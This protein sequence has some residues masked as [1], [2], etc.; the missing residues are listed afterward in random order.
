MNL[1]VL[2]SLLPVALLVVALLVPAAPGMTV[3]KQEAQS[4]Y[5]AD[6]CWIS[7]STTHVACDPTGTHG[8]CWF[9]TSWGSITVW[10]VM[11]LP[12]GSIGS[13]LIYPPCPCSAGVNY[14]A[15]GGVCTGY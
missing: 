14:G 12:P 15:T 6:I 4:V 3:D 5:G 11:Q 9:S 13:S 2:A 1:R 7:L 8:W 10:D